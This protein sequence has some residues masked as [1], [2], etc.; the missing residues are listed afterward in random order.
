MPTHELQSNINSCTFRVIS[1][2]CRARAPLHIR[3]KTRIIYV[4]DNCRLFDKSRIVLTVTRYFFRR[5]QGIHANE[6]NDNV[7]IEVWH[8]Q[9]FA[10]TNQCKWF[11]DRQFLVC[12]NYVSVKTRFNN[13]AQFVC[14]VTI[15]AW[16]I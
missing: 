14:L 4:G 15:S 2:V 1:H 6:R 13:S 8:F 7:L 11:V 5:L 3:A 16:M 10:P 9:T 12:S